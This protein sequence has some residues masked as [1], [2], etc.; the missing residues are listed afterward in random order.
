MRTD[1]FRRY[2]MPH[3]TTDDYEVILDLV[4]LFVLAIVSITASIQRK[5]NNTE[6]NDEW[7]KEEG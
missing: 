2:T 6:K 4:A 5:R 7:P 3:L 1:I